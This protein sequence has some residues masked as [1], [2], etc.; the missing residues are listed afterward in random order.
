MQLSNY[1]MKTRILLL[2]A[3]FFL[4]SF[5]MYAQDRPVHPSSVV[6]GTFIGISKPL[7]DL[8]KITQQELDKLA[9][10]S[11]TKQLNESLKLRSFPFAATALPKGPDPV[12]QKT[13]GESAG[14][15]APIANFT[16]QDSPYYPPD[17]NGAAGPSHY[18]ETINCV[19]SIYNKSGTLVAG[20]TA[21]NTLFGS[22]P[23]ATYNDGDPVVLYDEQAGRWLA[24][25][26]SISGSTNYVMMAVSTTSDPTGTWYQYSFVVATMPDYPKFGVWR[27]GYYMGDNNPSAKDI[28]VF[29][30]SQMLIGGTAL[31]V[32]FDNPYRPTSVDGFMMVPPVD[33][34]GT[35]APAGSP[36]TFIAFNDDAVGGG[37]DQLWIYEL[38]VDWT[39]TANSTFNRVQQLAV[40]A[41]SSNFGSDQNNIFQSGTTQR[42]DAIPQVIMNVPQ[43]RNFGT[44]QTIVCCHTVNV[45][46]NTSTDHAGIRWYELRR[47]AG[48]TNS[49]WS[50]RQQ[51]TYA[52][53][54]NSRW[55]GSIM[56]NG[57][58]KIA[59]GYS[60]A[61]SSMFPGIR[62][63]GQSTSAYN[64]GA[65]VLDLPEEIIQ[66][67]AYSQTGQNR[68][69]DYSNMS[70]D[71]SDDNTFWFA[72]EYI[73]SGGARKTK[74]A[75]FKYGNSPAIATLAATSVTPTSA[76]INGTVNPNGLA[77]TYYF[78]WGTSVSY[79]NQ[80]TVT[81]A[82][83]GTSIVAV[84]ANLTGLTAG[85]TYHFRVV[86]TNSDG[87]GTGTDMSFTPAL[88]VVT[89][90]APSAI[91]GST[92]TTGGNVTADGG[93]SITACGICW[94]TSA[95]PTI[96]GNHTT[97]GS[98][99]GAFTTYL[100]GL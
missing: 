19:Y 68:W 4:G 95:L 89:T 55:M 97:D 65:G 27:D 3:V 29:Q 25:E 52:P 28:Y 66:T 56:L 58:G 21:M 98:G 10:R 33:N 92:A 76:T 75:S 74:I 39:N 11:K 86:A 51:G 2:I 50:I 62:Y 36:G 45:D 70:V 83:S 32:G 67:G 61:G 22:V 8:P 41:F 13:M 57:S 96:A 35:F 18:M 71:P 42:V 80:T 59:L 49:G 60:I 53:D 54:A 72:S 7:R 82:G 24:T 34:D 6:T 30:R 9:E 47:A 17:C 73:G 46:N 5:V 16:G 69:G 99:I 1:I 90:T 85:V 78:D 81:S 64:T 44:Y 20:P 63:C 23:G 14:S 38:T 26:F 91:T 40:A 79:G 93:L 37:S 48:V 43:Y 88:A 84:S 77:T 87:T 12:W 94:S 31:S 100:T 15:K